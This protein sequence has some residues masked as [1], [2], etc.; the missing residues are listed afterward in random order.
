[1]SRFGPTRRELRFR[2]GWS[3]LGIV[4]LAGLWVAGVL[5]EGPGRIEILALA[6]LF[7]GGSAIWSAWKLRQSEDEDD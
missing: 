4:V 3:V 2:L 7:F 1:M 6:G 5:P